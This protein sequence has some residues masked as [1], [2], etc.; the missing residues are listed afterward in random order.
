MSAPGLASV[1]IEVIFYRH[2]E[3]ERR[4]CCDVTVRGFQYNKAGFRFLWNCQFDQAR[5]PGCERRCRDLNSRQI[6][7]CYAIEIRADEFQRL[8][9]F[10]ARRSTKLLRTI[11][12]IAAIVVITTNDE[13][14]H[15]YQ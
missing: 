14:T 5:V 10:D 8:T 2:L 12:V 15:P 9:V 1:V 11:A 3:V 13:R 6:D 7:S 4:L